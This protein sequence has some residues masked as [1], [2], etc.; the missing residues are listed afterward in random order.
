MQTAQTLFIPF[1]DVVPQTLPIAKKQQNSFFATKNQQN[2][3]FSRKNVV[4]L[5]I[6]KNNFMINAQN[7]FVYNIN[8]PVTELCEKLESIGR[9]TSDFNGKELFPLLSHPNENVRLSAV[10][11]IGR[12]KSLEYVN[13][14]YSI[15]REDTSTRVKREAVSSIGRMR[16]FEVIDKLIEMTK[17]A[18]PKIICQAIRGLLVFKGNHNVDDTLKSLR[19]HPN[20][21]IKSIIHKEYFSNLDKKTSSLKH[22]DSY[23]FMQ[24]I[25]VNADVLETL[26]CVPNESIH[27]TFTSPP[28]YNARDYSIYTSYEEYLNFLHNVFKETHRVTKEGRFLVVNTSPIIVPR[29]SRAHSSKRYP[30]PFD[31]HAI[32]VKQ[33]WEFIDDIVW[34]KPEYSVKNRVGGF[35]QHRKPLGYKPNSVTEYLMVYRKKTDKLLDWNIHQYSKEVVEDSKV[36]GNF[37]TSNVWLINPKSDKVHSAV[38]PEELCK[39]VIQY[40]SF[41]GDLVFDPF[42]GSGTLA[43]AAKN[44]QRYFFLTEIEKKYVDYMKTL[45]NTNSVLDEKKV[46]YLTIEEFKKSIIL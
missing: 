10:K 16:S 38:F 5:R 20:E 17:D 28:Y 25:V 36:F 42:G 46:Q 27:L 44:M 34:Q 39:R 26:K 1:T 3:C 30:I 21:M 31:L 33:G 19:N 11:V 9:I 13:K 4:P 15:A 45:L 37:D 12:L 14:L 8:A 2:I 35:Q 24:N 7:Q 6:K 43:R 29:V 18:D 32:L 41:K 40:Y 22:T 23:S